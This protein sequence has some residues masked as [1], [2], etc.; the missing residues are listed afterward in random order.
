MFTHQTQNASRPWAGWSGLPARIDGQPARPVFMYPGWPGQP[1]RGRRQPAAAVNSR[2][3]HAPPRV[4]VGALANHTKPF[5][6]RCRPIKPNAQHL[7]SHAPSHTENMFLPNEP[8]FIHAA[9]FSLW[10]G[11]KRTQKS[12]LDPA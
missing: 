12:N 5:S 6:N 10:P 9:A 1:G 3:A 4:V 8:V 2:G 11:Q 7:F